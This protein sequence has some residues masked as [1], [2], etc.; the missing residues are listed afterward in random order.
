M[1]THNLGYP[2]IGSN[3]EL[4]KA[5][6]QFWQGKINQQHLSHAGKEIRRAN[7]RLQQAAK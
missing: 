5:N 6:E 3:R 2:R 4:K 1:Q 7:W